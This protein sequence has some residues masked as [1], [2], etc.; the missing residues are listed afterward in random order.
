[1]D[2]GSKQDDGMT[3]IVMSRAAATS[4]HFSEAHGTVDP[5]SYC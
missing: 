2:G 3:V 5:Y 1:M 4:E